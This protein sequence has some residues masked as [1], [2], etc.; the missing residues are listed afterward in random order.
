MP[1]DSQ[2]LRHYVEGGS[3]AAFKELV[4]RHLGLVYHSALRRLGAEAHLAPDIAQTVFILLARK[5]RTLR[6]HPSLVGWLHA[7]TYFTTTR[8]LRTEWRRRIREQEAQTMMEDRSEPASMVDWKTLRPFPGVKRKPTILH[9]RDV[10]ADLAP[11]HAARLSRKGNHPL[12][13]SRRAPA[14]AEES[15]APVSS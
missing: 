15:Q 3:E 8:A 7:T 10:P 4:E 1:D 5:A 12:G 13:L 6:G 9:R 14:E 11:R 2:L